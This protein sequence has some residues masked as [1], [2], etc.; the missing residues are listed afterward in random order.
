M[1]AEDRNDNIGTHYCAQGAPGALTLGIDQ[2]GGMVAFRVQSI[3]GD[4]KHAFGTGG[5]AKRTTFAE[6]LSNFDSAFGHA[7]PPNKH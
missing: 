6:V 1:L 3:R 5:D 7:G 2:L 4:G